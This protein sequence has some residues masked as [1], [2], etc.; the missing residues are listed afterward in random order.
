MD[1]GSQVR[2]SGVSVHMTWP[3]TAPLS[4]LLRW[5]NCIRTYR[6]SMKSTNPC[7]V[8]KWTR[9]ANTLSKTKSE[10]RKWKAAT[11]RNR[12]L[13]ILESALQKWASNPHSTNENHQRKISRSS[14][15]AH[16]PDQGDRRSTS[17]KTPIFKS[18]Q[19]MSKTLSNRCETHLDSPYNGTLARGTI[20]RS[21]NR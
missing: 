2:N 21:S 5:T 16:C 4:I 14:I 12:S 19:E 7:R 13:K 6:K 3:R 8:S 18:I 15:P 9:T 11:W 1:K 20:I 10:E 17:R